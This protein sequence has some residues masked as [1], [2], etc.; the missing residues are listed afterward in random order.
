M[1][2]LKQCCL[3]KISD[4]TCCVSD[5]NGSHILPCEYAKIYVH[6][7]QHI[8]HVVFRKI[9]TG[10]CFMIIEDMYR[11]YHFFRGNVVLMSETSMNITTEHSLLVEPDTYSYR[12]IKIKTSHK[13]VDKIIKNMRLLMDGNVAVPKKVIWDM[14]YQWFIFEYDDEIIV[15]YENLE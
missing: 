5:K 2:N 6:D 14:T 15:S 1:I 4:D 13:F 8:D 11:R 9:I 7:I 12:W 10:T 3:E